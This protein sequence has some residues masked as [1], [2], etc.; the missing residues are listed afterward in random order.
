MAL[1]PGLAA[2]HELKTPL[3]ALLGFARLLLREAPGPLNEVQRE[4]VETIVDEGE[5]LRRSVERLLALKR[6]QHDGQGASSRGHEA[7]AVTPRTEPGNRERSGTGSGFAASHTVAAVSDSMDLPAVVEEVV[8]RL[9]P[10]AEQRRIGLAYEGAGGLPP[11]AGDAE[12]LRQVVAN[13]VDNALKFTPAGGRVAVSIAPWGQQGVLVSVADDGPG[14][15]A[16]EQARIFSP[17]YRSPQTADGQPGAGLGLAIAAEIVERHGGAIWVESHVGSG[18]TFSVALP[19]ASEGP[20]ARGEGGPGP[21]RG[22]SATP[23]PPPMEWGDA[24]PDGAGGRT[25]A[26]V[27]RQQGGEAASTQPLAPGPQLVACA[28]V[29]SYAAL[30]ELHQAWRTHL[31]DVPPHARSCRGGVVYLAVDDTAALGAD[32]LRRLPA[33]FPFTCWLVAEAEAWDRRR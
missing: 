29:T 31:P 11:V 18:S 24:R 20:G 32:T 33:S 17:Y 5:R 6:P 22:L 16:G 30:A 13:L 14:I 3:N 15:P 8:Q 7:A 28:P 26:T 12:Q 9:V 19:A 10:V 25:A 21:T 23:S 1:A 2:A 27:A 4:F